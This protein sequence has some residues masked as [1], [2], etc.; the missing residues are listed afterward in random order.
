MKEEKQEETKWWITVREPGHVL[1]AL[2]G[3]ESEIQ[4]KVDR[5]NSTDEHGSTVILGSYDSREEC[6]VEFEMLQN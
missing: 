4:A 3:T 5:L 6:A 1:S 2:K